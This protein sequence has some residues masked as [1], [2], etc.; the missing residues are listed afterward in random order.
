MIQLY[1]IIDAVQY[2]MHQLLCAAI[3]QPFQLLEF[4]R[5]PSRALPRA[6]LESLTFCLTLVKSSKARFLGSGSANLS[7]FCGWRFDAQEKGV[8]RLKDGVSRIK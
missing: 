7:V 1:V 3:V 5:F 6:V 8:S 4:G 2:A